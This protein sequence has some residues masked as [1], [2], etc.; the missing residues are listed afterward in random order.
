MMRTRDMGTVSEELRPPPRITTGNSTTTLTTTI[1]NNSNNT[2]TNTVPIN[3]I[4]SNTGHTPHHSNNLKQHS[5]HSPHHLSNNPPPPPQRTPP[6]L[7]HLSSPLDHIITNSPRRPSSQ[8]HSNLSLLHPLLPTNHHHNHHLCN[9]PRPPN[10]NHHHK[11]PPHL[12]RQRQRQRR[13]QSLLPSPRCPHKTRIPMPL[14]QRVLLRQLHLRRTQF[15]LHRQR[16][17]LRRNKGDR[18]RMSKPFN[19][20]DR[21]VREG[22]TALR[23]IVQN[24]K[25]L[26]INSRHPININIEATNIMQRPPATTTRRL[27]RVR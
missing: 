18:K 1:N 27:L 8:R 9:T 11:K 16:V 4:I 3:N 6:P 21:V 19:P 20:R 22:P 26:H 14:H 24:N 10:S 15:P 25:M 2:N 5:P 23:A 7:P 12:R 17:L 13:Q